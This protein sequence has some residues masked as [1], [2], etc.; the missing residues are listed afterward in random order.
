MEALIFFD[1]TRK[2]ARQPMIRKNQ[3]VA[4]DFAHQKNVCESVVA[5]YLMYVDVFI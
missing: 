2:C 1:I 4:I 5:I 3:D